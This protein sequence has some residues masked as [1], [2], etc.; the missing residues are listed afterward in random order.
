MTGAKLKSLKEISDF[1]LF[2]YKIV[3][4]LSYQNQIQYVEILRNKGISTLH[5]K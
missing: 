4:P 1:F 5:Q 3:I 2:S